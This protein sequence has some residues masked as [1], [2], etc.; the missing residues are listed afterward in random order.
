MEN[1]AFFFQIFNLSR[2]NLLL[3]A[4][5]IFGAEYL[6]FVAYFLALILAV[7]REN[8]GRKIFILTIIG[9]IIAQIITYLIRIFYFEPRPF[10]TFPITPL[11]DHTAAASFPSTHTS[12]MA[13]LAF[14]YMIYNSKY[15]LLFLFFMLWVGFARV[16]T[17]VHYPFDIVGGVA[18]GLVSVRL[19]WILK[20]WLKKRAAKL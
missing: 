9:I 13:A 15:T 6:I 18:T 3:D 2:Q 11:I 4:L 12:T 1:T 20:N 5:M 17:G 8:K 14:S 7:K 10:I 19:A 16:F